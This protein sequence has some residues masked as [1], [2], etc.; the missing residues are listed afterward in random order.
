MEEYLFLIF[1]YFKNLKKKDYA[2]TVSEMVI[3]IIFFIY[4]IVIYN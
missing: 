2:Y 4:S 1:L 3:K